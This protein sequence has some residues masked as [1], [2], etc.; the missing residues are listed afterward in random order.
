MTA[1][2]LD[3][4]ATTPIAPEAFEAMCHQ[5]GRTGNPHAAHA[6]GLSAA[7]AVE[8]GR[9]Q[10]AALIGAEPAEIVFTSGATEANNLAILGFAR[11]ARR[12]GSARATIVTSAIEHP[13]VSAPADLLKREGFRHVSVAVG[14]DGVVDRQ[15]FAAAVRDAVVVSIGLANGEIGTIQPISQLTE[16]AHAAGA[17]VHCDATQAVGRIPV[18]VFA[19]DVDALSLSS[20]KMYGP[21]GIGA[22]FVSSAV[23]FRPEPLLA[24]GGQEQGRRPGT[25]PTMLVA[26]FGA[27]AGL[28]RRQLSADA[29]HGELLRRLFLE[30]LGSIATG[31]SLNVQGMPRLPGSLNLRFDGVDGDSLVDQLAGSL[32]IATGSACSAGKVEPSHVLSA[33]GLNE[34]EA[35][36]ALRLYFHRY[37]DEDAV[38]NAAHTLSSAVSRFRLGA[39]E[40][41]Q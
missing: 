15:A 18:D 40:V 25:V 7:A 35:R 23:P 19:L 27:A 24:G 38:V 4:H 34:N 22:L 37:L 10:V 2:Y 14:R 36:S 39:G 5:A 1:I 41:V 30:T 26:G 33:I 16:L 20:H 13:S 8:Q 9:A 17:I 6:A 12:A 3:G 31:W 29:E 32:D 21:A 11:A 28:A